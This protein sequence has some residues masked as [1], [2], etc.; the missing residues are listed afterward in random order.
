M[1]RFRQPM[2]LSLVKCSRGWESELLS[3]PTVLYPPPLA[4]VADPIRCRRD[5]MKEWLWSRWLCLKLDCV[6]SVWLSWFAVPEG[7]P[8]HRL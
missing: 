8:G 5:Q 6:I 4:R 3:A 7:G 2:T 1:T